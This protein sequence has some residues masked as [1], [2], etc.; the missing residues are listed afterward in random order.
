MSGHCVGKK[1][2]HKTRVT[3]FIRMF[4]KECS[5]KYQ[6]NNMVRESFKKTVGCL[7]QTYEKRRW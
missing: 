5:L 7:Y 4:I 1:S 6:L 2:T 3:S